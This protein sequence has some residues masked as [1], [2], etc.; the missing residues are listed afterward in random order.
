MSFLSHRTPQHVHEDGGAL[1]CPWPIS[2]LL[3]PL[4]NGGGTVFSLLDVRTGKPDLPSHDVISYI[5]GIKG[6][7]NQ[8]DP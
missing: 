2:G 4:C 1:F 6:S 8:E 3:L 5:L 7:Q